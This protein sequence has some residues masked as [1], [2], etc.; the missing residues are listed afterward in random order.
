VRLFSFLQ[1]EQKE[2]LGLLQ[3]GTFLEYF[4]LMLYVHMAVVLNELFFPKT[5]PHTASLLAAFAFCSTFVFRP[6]GALLF[7]WMGDKVG[8]KS[9]IILTTSLMSVSCIVMANLPTYAQIGISAAWIMTICRM[10]QGM[11]S[12]GELIGAE[13]YIA[14]SVQRPACYPAV[15]SIAVVA[16]LGV[17]T[18][19]G[20]ATLTTSFFFDWR[21]AFWVGAVIALVGA[22][23]R[24]RLRETPDF[25]N[26]KRQQMQTAAL[27]ISQDTELKK[28]KLTPQEGRPSWQERVNPKTLM[29]YFFMHCGYPLSFYLAYLYFTPILKANYGYTPENIIQRNFLLSLVFLVPYV[30]LAVL[31]YRIHPI[32]ILKVKVIFMISMMVMLPILVINSNTSDQ[33]FLIQALILLFAFDT[34]PG[35]VILIYH[36]PIYRRFRFASVLW[37]STRAMIYIVTSFGLVYLTEYFGP[38]GLWIITLPVS[39][40]FLYG[41]HHFEGLERKIGKYPSVPLKFSDKPTSARLKTK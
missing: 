9:T 16:N 18:A 8:R 2:A 33:L 34:V 36:L 23:A 19:L 22:A 14:E 12:M 32:K 30:T 6:I 25:L 13:I 31:S 4:D 39:A 27:G 7:G 37:A 11:S 24:T 17:M 3:I 35:S 15:A 41:V 26:L 29:C 40:A 5:N 1:R 10:A 20:I 38:Y 28:E 21:I